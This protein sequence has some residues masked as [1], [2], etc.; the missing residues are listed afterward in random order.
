[1]LLFYAK[2]TYPAVTQV[3]D[4]DFVTSC[5][6]LIT[7]A[8]A[9]TPF[10]RFIPATVPLLRTA[11][12]GLF[13]PVSVEIKHE[14]FCQQAPGTR[15]FLTQRQAIEYWDMRK[16]GTLPFHY[17]RDNTVVQTRTTTKSDARRAKKRAYNIE[18]Y[19]R[20]LAKQMVE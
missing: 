7:P 17:L 18:R 12:R 16:L 2:N 9:N 6:Q 4:I 3:S 14:I 10:T 15:R 20:S 11:L 8:T 13:G 19:N 1:M 5:Q